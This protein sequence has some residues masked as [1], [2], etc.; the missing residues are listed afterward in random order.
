M[1]PVKKIQRATEKGEDRERDRQWRRREE[2]D[3]DYHCS[4]S[5]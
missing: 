5:T 4:S 1:E 3:S 2:E